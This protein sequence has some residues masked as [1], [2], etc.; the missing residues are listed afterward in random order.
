LLTM[1][2]Q[3]QP[4]TSRSRFHLASPIVSEKSARVAAPGGHRTGMVLLRLDR[5]SRKVLRRLPEPVRV[6]PETRQPRL[7]FPAQKPTDLS[8]LRPINPSVG[9]GSS[10]RPIDFQSGPAD[11]TA[12]ILGLDNPHELF[13][14]NLPCS[15]SPR[16]T[17]TGLT[18]TSSTIR[19]KVIA[20]EPRRI[21][22]LAATGAVFRVSYCH[23]QLLLLGAFR[24]LLSVFVLPAFTGTSISEKS[25]GQRYQRVTAARIRR[26][27]FR[28]A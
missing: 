6:T 12:A 2:A 28:P 15:F 4:P 1:I 24:R 26:K 10:A 9:E 13:S 8:I 17:R 18:P 7:A 23:M 5:S 22:V 19:A 21:A 16:H 11:G 27:P 3:R 14:G 20:G 25:C